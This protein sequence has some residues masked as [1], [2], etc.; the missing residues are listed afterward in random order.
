MAKLPVRTGHILLQV[1][2]VLS[3]IP[4]GAF[5]GVDALLPWLAGVAVASNIVW[6]VARKGKVDL[7]EVLTYTLFAVL[8]LGLSAAVVLFLV[9]GD[10]PLLRSMWH[11]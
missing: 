11:T 1:V 8:L 6:Q 3:A 5:W 7:W 9:F 4:V 10:Q 2:L